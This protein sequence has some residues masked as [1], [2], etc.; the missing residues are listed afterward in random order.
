VLWRYEWPYREGEHTFAVR[1]YDGAGELQTTEANP[2]FPRGATGIFTERAN[3]L[4]L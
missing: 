3:L 2:T 4:S 1:A